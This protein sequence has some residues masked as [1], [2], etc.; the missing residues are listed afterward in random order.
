MTL[1][2]KL[3][4]LRR[5]HNFTQEQLAELLGVSR[6]AVSRWESDTAYP[7]TEKLIR[8]GKLFHCSMDYLLLDEIQEDSAP[9]APAPEST[10]QKIELNTLCYERV[11]KKKIGSLPLWHINIGYGRTAKGVFAIGLTS[12]G[13]VSIG[14]AS[15]GVISFGVLSLGLLSIGVLALGLIAI[16]SIALGVLAA[17]AVALGI[18]S[19]GSCAIGDFSVGAA[20]IGRYAALGDA[21]RG[22][23]ALGFSEATGTRY[24][25]VSPAAVWDVP[26][27]Q[28]A[29]NECVPNYLTL[30]KALFMLFIK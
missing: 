5:E 24:Q 22:Q 1:G 9:S 15:L 6:Q 14:L 18:F 7:E 17:G 4:K 8:L 3:A 19:L 21:A 10:V 26:Q 12:K 13:I 2:N 23:I 20:A 27:V 16:G 29:L 11:S 30:F 25:A 28:A